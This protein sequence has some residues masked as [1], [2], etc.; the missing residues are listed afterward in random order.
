MALFRV[1]T[2]FIT[3]CFYLPFSEN[4]LWNSNICLFPLMLPL[5]LDDKSSS[6]GNESSAG[7]N[8][9]WHLRCYLLKSIKHWRKLKT[10]KKSTKCRCDFL[11]L[12]NKLSKSTMK[13]KLRWPMDKYGYITCITKVLSDQIWRTLVVWRNRHNHENFMQI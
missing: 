9:V 3:Y 11:F 2:S 4:Y 6:V 8:F 5:F 10:E 12:E 1:Q 7:I 13:L